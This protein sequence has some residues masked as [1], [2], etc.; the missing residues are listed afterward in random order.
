MK[1]TTTLIIKT[2]TNKTLSF[3]KD[4]IIQALVA[5]RMIDAEDKQYITNVGFGM[6]YSGNFSSGQRI[7]L[8]ESPLEV[9]TRREEIK[10]KSSRNNHI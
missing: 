2:T 10:E 1:Q 9:R 7:D 8:D 3:N 4:D 5:A 6:P